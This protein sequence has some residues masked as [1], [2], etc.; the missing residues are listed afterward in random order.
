[1]LWNPI[2]LAKLHLSS[3]GLNLFS[4]DVD[5]ELNTILYNAHLTVFDSINDGVLVLD[6]DN[7][8]VSC[9]PSARRIIRAVSSQPVTD[10]LDNRHV[11]SVLSMWP[12]L[13]AYFNSTT[14]ALSTSV[15]SCSHGVLRSFEI[16][17][18]PI[19]DHEGQFTGRVI[20]IHETTER[21][22]AAKALRQRK[23]QLR[24]MVE[25]LQH[26]DQN[27]TSHIDVLDDELRRS[28]TRIDL[29]LNNLR[30]DVSDGLSDAV[31]RLEQEI[32]SLYH[33]FETI[34]AKDSQPNM[35]SESLPLSTALR[36]PIS[37]PPTETL[38]QMDR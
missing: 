23:Q 14:R 21:D 20:L 29:Q 8:V 16:D 38:I 7:F 37:V 35:L 26:M 13:R 17:I 36:T 11:D 6:Q 10:R 32:A 30:E 12:A 15:S 24:H 1:M 31:N 22:N 5:G 4:R 33:R 19:T 2:R 28:L 3:T 18:T 34:L 25:R 9:N 27:R